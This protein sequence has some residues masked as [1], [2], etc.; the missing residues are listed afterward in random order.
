MTA[1]IIL[2]MH[3]R[4]NTEGDSNSETLYLEIDRAM[5]DRLM[6]CSVAAK[7]LNAMVSIGIAGGEELGESDVS[8]VVTATSEGDITFGY[9]KPVEN[10]WPIT[11][12]VT[13][14]MTAGMI[15]RSVRDAS[16]LPGQ[17]AIAF[18]PNQSEDLYVFTLEQIRNVELCDLILDEMSRDPAAY[19]ETLKQNAVSS[20][21]KKY[22][23]T[24]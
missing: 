1:I 23:N 12:F 14:E 21:N 24:A 15:S 18:L 13:G 9:E 19:H 10:A 22:L 7:D 11:T 6:K 8:V 2:A 16:G 5:A 20:I 4:Q 17:T 3:A